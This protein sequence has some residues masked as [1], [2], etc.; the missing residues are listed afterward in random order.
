MDDFMITRPV[1]PY[2]E[3]IGSI[4]LGMVAMLPARSPL[5]TYFTEIGLQKHLTH[6]PIY[7]SQ[8]AAS[9]LPPVFYLTL[10]NLVEGKKKTV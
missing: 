10:Q 8:V 4:F 3:D 6:S 5:S 7:P 9:T 1:F 2:F